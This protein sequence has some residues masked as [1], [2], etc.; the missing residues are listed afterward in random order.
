MIKKTLVSACLLVAVLSCQTAPDG[1]I[2]IEGWQP[3]EVAARYDAEGLWE[4]INGAADTFLSYGF[5]GVTVQDF[6]SNG[7][8]VTVSAY[9]MGTPLNAFGIFR[10]EAPPDGEVLDIGGGAVVSPPY[11]GLLRK[12]RHYVKVDVLEGELDQATGSSLLEAIARALP[13][14]DGLPPEFAAL[15]ASGMVSGSAQFSGSGLLGLAELDNCVHASYRDDAGEEFR[16][17]VVLVEDEEAADALWTELSA[18]WTAAEVDGAPMLYREVPYSGLVGLA[19]GPKGLLGVAD[20]VDLQ[21]LQDRLRF[22]KA[23]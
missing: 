13:G 15:P 22:V 10:T 17:F 1:F 7:V 8:S 6:T 23:D 12:D 5:E 9:D 2:T 14:A 11:Q 3:Q 20:C 16:A 21:Q 19:G 4:L 18:E